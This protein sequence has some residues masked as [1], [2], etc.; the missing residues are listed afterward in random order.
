M[1]LTLTACSPD[2]TEL[3]VDENK[4][5]PSLPP[6]A[7]DSKTSSLE[8]LPGLRI[9]K[10]SGQIVQ[11]DFRECAA[12]WSDT[13]ESLP[14]L[15]SL[16]SLTLAG[17][18]VTDEKLKLVGQL[19]RLR[20]LRLIDCPITDQGCK[21]LSS[22]TELQ[23]AMFLR[24]PVGPGALVAVS[25]ASSLTKLNLRGTKVS[26]SDIAQGL[27]KLVALK[28]LE[29]SETSL[30]DAALKT[31]IELPMLE[32][33]NLWRT[34]VT[35]AGLKVLENSKLKKLNLDDLPG[36]TDAGLESVIK[37]PQLEWLHLGKTK[38]TD[39]GL[40]TLSQLTNL[41]ELR[42]NDTAV[43]EAAVEQLGKALPALKVVAK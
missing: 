13:L 37:I 39:R 42:V 31:I 16:E 29:V 5:P 36:V 18:E 17:T 6:D 9:Q 38:V 4:P 22:L 26:S 7:A 24:C 15:A 35:D 2:K 28:D 11:V 23:E 21:A 34:Q 10:K 40:L 25:Q 8:S 30:D 33:L 43:T 41:S 32:S 20:V 19:S 12:G 14:N 27:E 3:S 1:L